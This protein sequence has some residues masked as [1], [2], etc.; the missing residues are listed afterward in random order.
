MFSTLIKSDV[1]DARLAD[2]GWCVIDCR[3]DLADPAAGEAAWR[4]AHIPGAR[5][6]H[7]END[8]SGP[9]AP[10]TGRHPLPEPRDLVE[11]FGRW[12]IA[13]DTQVVAYD[14]GSGAMA[15]R[16]WW[17]LRWLGHERVAVLDGGWRAWREAGHATTNDVPVR[18]PAVFVQRPSLVAVVDSDDMLRAVN[19]EADW[20]VVDARAAERFRGDVETVDPVAGHV[21]GAINR[22]FLD[23]I[24]AGGRLLAPE[25]LRER[26]AGIAS[27]R[28]DRVAHYCGSGVTAC[29]NVLAME[30][31]GLPGSRLYAGSW[32][33]WIRDPARP[34]ATGY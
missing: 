3:F 23:N 4:T 30:H 34:V 18:R 26:F 28:A 25:I 21:P 27:G 13:A 31:A 20:R 14:G 32:S 22:P 16:L 15:A 6:A 7:L 19:G 5:Y 29:L 24:D 11:K 8:L 9:V 12:G 2:P 1:L 17:L 10:H 33:E